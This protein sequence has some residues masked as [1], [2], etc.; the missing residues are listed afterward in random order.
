MGGSHKQIIGLGSGPQNFSLY[1]IPTVQDTS[2]SL[3]V[4]GK[5]SP[6]GAIQCGMVTFLISILVDFW[7]VVQIFELI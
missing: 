4:D 1:N 6:V 3:E 7:V 2:C 5:L